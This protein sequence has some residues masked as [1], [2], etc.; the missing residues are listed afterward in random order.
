[1]FANFSPSNDKPIFF[2]SHFVILLWTCSYPLFSNQTH[3]QLSAIAIRLTLNTVCNQ[4][5]FSIAYGSFS[6]SHRKATLISARSRLRVHGESIYYNDTSLYAGSIADS[7]IPVCRLSHS[8]N[9]DKQS[10]SSIAMQNK[11]IIDVVWLNAI[12]K[13]QLA[14]SAHFGSVYA[15]TCRTKCPFCVQLIRIFACGAGNSV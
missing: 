14:G 8:W 7:L 3:W 13:R 9:F 15:K 1:M 12:I 4:R 6:S 10:E 11:R 5:N 2:N